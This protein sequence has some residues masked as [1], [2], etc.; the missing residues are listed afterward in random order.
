M[1]KILHKTH[2]GYVGVANMKFCSI[3]SKFGSQVYKV[4]TNALCKT[5]KIKKVVIQ[6]CF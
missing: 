2:F 3:N 1:K 5:E 6:L 4:L